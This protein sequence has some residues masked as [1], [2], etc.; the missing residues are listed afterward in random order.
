M[1]ETNDFFGNGKLPPGAELH[2]LTCF[3]NVALVLRAVQ[4]AKELLSHYWPDSPENLRLAAEAL[5]NIDSSSISQ[6][7]TK[8][9]MNAT[10]EAEQ[11]LNAGRQKLA[12]PDKFDELRAYNKIAE[13]QGCLIRVID[14]TAYSIKSAFAKHKGY[15]VENTLDAIIALAKVENKCIK[16]I[17]SDYDR[18]YYATK[19]N[20]WIDFD[21]NVLDLF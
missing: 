10:D 18:I 14:Y 6:L 17:R 12:T 7:S 15:T 3:G 20:N 16:N 2:K 21:T 13:P 11:I 1:T 19:L 9:V 8:A 5:M 4:Y